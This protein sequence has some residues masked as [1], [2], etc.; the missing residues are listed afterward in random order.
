MFFD[1]TQM[2]LFAAIVLTAG[3]SL[4]QRLWA[5]LLVTCAFV[6]AWYTPGMPLARGLLAF[7]ATYGLFVAVKIAFSSKERLS[8]R[9]RLLQAI[10]LPGS[11]RAGRVPATLSPGAIGRMV[12]DLTLAGLA[13]LLLLH[14]RHLVGAIY[15][16]ERLSA[17]VLLVYAGVQFFFD[18][19]SFC[20]LAAGL[21]LDSL[22]RTPIAARSLAEFWGQRWNRV[23]S[24]WLHT[25][26]YLPLARR[27]CPRL[28]VFCAFLVSGVL[29]GW[30]ILVAIGIS[31]ALAILLFFVV[32][33]VFV[34]AEHR[35]G[36]RAWPVPV[37]RGWILAVLLASS[38]L[39]IDPYLRVF[40]L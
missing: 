2:G 14:A 5:A 17:G 8:I 3:R 40:D 38:P 29:H 23:V 22:H 39:I 16:I 28:G 33:G 36:V 18:F 4:I 24:A 19:V 34:L 11:V 31:G 37:A 30:V 13:L 20:F 6:L 1:Y 9:D 26:V 27:R 25:F 7:L 21:S 32:Q 15:S 35:L 12:I 10:T